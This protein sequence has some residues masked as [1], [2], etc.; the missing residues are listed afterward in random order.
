MRLSSI[1]CSIIEELMELAN[2][3]FPQHRSTQPIGV[4]DGPAANVK[5]GAIAATIAMTIKRS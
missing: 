1:Q 4:T 2:H 3:G 5:A